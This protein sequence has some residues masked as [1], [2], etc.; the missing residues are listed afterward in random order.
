M[1]GEVSRLFAIKWKE[2]LDHHWHLVDK[3][4]SMH[5]VVYNKDLASLTITFY[6]FEGDHH[7]TL[8]YYGQCL[9]LL[10][11]FKTSSAAKTFPKWNSFYH[12]VPN[13]VTFKVLLNDYKVTCNSLDVSSTMYYFMKEKRFTHLI[14]EDCAECHIV[15]NDWR[16]TTKIGCEWRNFSKAHDFTLGMEIVFEFPD[17][18]VNYVLVWLCL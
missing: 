7:V 5:D 18:N 16:K 4:D 11:I 2:Q 13:S 9:F 17:P 10:T 15:N 12:Q 14:I 1:Y 3:H 8:T 6:G